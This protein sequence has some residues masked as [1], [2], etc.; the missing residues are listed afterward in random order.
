MN[1]FGN[2]ICPPMRLGARPIAGLSAF[3]IVV[4]LG[5]CATRPGPE[6]LALSPEMP[7]AKIETIYVATTRAVTPQDVYTDGRARQTNYAEF[8]ISIP[9]NHQPGQIEWPQGAPNPAT[10]FTAVADEPLDASAFEQKIAAHDHGKPVEATVFVHGY[11]TSFQEALFRFTQVTADSNLDAAAILFAWP[12]EARLAGYV[13]DKDAVL[14]SRDQLVALLTM[15]AKKRSIGKITVVAHSMG[16]WLML[17]ALRQLRLTGRNDVINRLHVI[18]ASPD[19]DIDVFRAGIDVIGPMSPPMTLLVS[20]DDKALAI[21]RRL[22]GNRMRVGALNVDDPRV[23]E[24]AEKAK[25][26]IVDISSLK[27]SDSFNHDRFVTL[28]AL[29]PRIE[30]AEA[31]GTGPDLRRTGAF[32][33]NSV[34]MTLS[35]PFTM[36]GSALSGE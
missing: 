2:A 7:G 24:A 4:G 28:A 23:E 19:I 1:F 18:L 27:G 15:L 31:N 10:S 5:G 35:S 14:Y 25:L 22:A 8:K 34:G 17:E 20:R 11:N 13:T 26:R 12:S 16:A 21:S 3:L 9:P 36:A 32:V 6:V 30:A 33:F 29:Y